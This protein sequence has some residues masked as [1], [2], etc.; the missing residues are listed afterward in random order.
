MRDPYEAA[1]HLGQ[2][3]RRPADWPEEEPVE[4]AAV[5]FAEL[6]HDEIGAW[7][8]LQ[9][10]HPTFENPFFRPE[11]SA[12]LSEYENDVEVAVLRVNDR[13]VGFW[14][15]QRGRGNVAFA[16]GRGLRSYEGV[17]CD[18]RVSWS[19]EALLEG[20]RLSAWKFEHLLDA[21]ANF[22]PY[23]WK[24]WKAPVI[25]LADGSESFLARKRRERSHTIELVLRKAAP[26]GA[27]R[28]SCATRFL[29]GR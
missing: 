11:F 8:A 12:L 21:Q 14:P 10:C 22:R 17:V 2:C 23:Y 25:D 1:T 5:R 6:T 7:S 13:C 20:C 28:R 3:V 19:P 24:L 16:D 15:F 4:I 9:R 26:S 18:P 29:H 27:R